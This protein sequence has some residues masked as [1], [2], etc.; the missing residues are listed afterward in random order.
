MQIILSP[1][2]KSENGQ[3]K[4]TDIGDALEYIDLLTDSMNIDAKNVF[5]SHAGQSKF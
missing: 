3:D 4:K 1:G 2:Q 5:G